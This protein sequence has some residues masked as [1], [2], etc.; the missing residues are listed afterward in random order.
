MLKDS[1]DQIE[2]KKE[3]NVDLGLT[4]SEEDALKSQIY[5]CWS[6]PLGLPNNENLLV[7]IKVKLKPDGTILKTEIL[8]HE[9]LNMP[10]QGFYKALAE[11]ALRVIKLCQPLTLPADGYERWKELILNFDARDIIG[12]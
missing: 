10:G 9:R 12:G 8:N 5:S 6:I 3:S 2:E 1:Q 7:R 4:L 11:S